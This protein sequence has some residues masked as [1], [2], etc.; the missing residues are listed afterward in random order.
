MQ[1]NEARQVADAA[2][3]SAAAKKGVAPAVVEVTRRLEAA[4]VV[5]LAEKRVADAK[6]QAQEEKIKILSTAAGGGQR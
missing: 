5:L 6:M 4:K 3:K 1:R 2:K